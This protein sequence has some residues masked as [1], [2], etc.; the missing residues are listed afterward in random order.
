MNMR[1]FTVTE[2]QKKYYNMTCHK[3]GQELQVG[4]KALKTMG[5]PPVKYYHK[6]CV[7]G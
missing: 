4:E 5:N 1:E 6:R 2:R 7:Y 3:C